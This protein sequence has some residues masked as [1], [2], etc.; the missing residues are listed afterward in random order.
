MHDPRPDRILEIGYAFWKSKVLLSA[1]EFGLFTVLAPGPLTLDQL[2]STLK[3]AERGARDFFD[4]L[5]SLNLLVR[6]QHGRYSNSP[7]S[8]CYLNRRS[9]LYIGGA[10]ER[11]NSGGYEPWAG[12]AT[13]L[14]SGKPW[15]TRLAR[16]YNALHSDRQASDAFLKGMTG[17]VLLPARALA[18]KFPWSE[19]RTVTD[20]GSAQGCCLV[21]IARVHA[22]IVGCGFDLP[23]V[24]PFFREYVREQN[25][26]ER[27]RFCPGDFFTDPLPKADVL[28]IGRV[29]HNWDLPTKK[30]LLQKAYAALP[31]GGKLVVYETLIDDDRCHHVHALLQSLNMLVMT[32]GGFDFT[33]ADCAGWLADV[34]FRQ[35]DVEPL[36]C[37][38]FMIVSTK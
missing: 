15:N 19:H 38:H 18:Q 34:G 32:K 11:L 36:A 17:G 20:V 23:P 33:A 7:E 10:L 12:L 9:N 16:G 27:L 2:V 6:D 37:D 3:L 22:H 4:S 28:V 30:M 21:E 26:S 31:V 24:A 13:A 5:V 14:R 1:V 25:L 8:A 35:C 29:L